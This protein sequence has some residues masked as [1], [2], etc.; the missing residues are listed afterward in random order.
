MSSILEW[1]EGRARD[2]DGL[3]VRRVLPHRGGR[4]IGP[5]IFFDH[6][7]PTELKPGHGMDVRPH[8]HIC[9]STV[10]YL[11]EGEILHR[12]S[13]GSVQT[14]T[15]GAINWMTAG[16]GIVHSERT[17]G[18]LRKT[19]GRMHGI[20]TW[21]AL[22]DAE[23]ERDPGFFHIPASDLPAWEKD[24]LQWNLLVGAAFGRK[25]ALDVYWP[26]SYLHV[27]SQNGGGTTLPAD[28]S[29]RGIYT[30]NGEVRIDGE[31][32]PVGTMA[33]LA[34]GVTPELRL[35]AG[36]SLMLIGGEPVG[37]RLIWWNFVAPT[38]ARLEQ[39]K[40]DWRAGRFA[41]VPDETEFIPMPGDEAAKP[42]PAGFN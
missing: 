21:V 14:I 16:R 1:I 20:Q 6:M 12:D 10:T 18:R 3:A 39:A 7:G 30:V 22:P 34:K 11:F 32:I 27:T 23:L 35:G 19:G 9:L 13:V 31:A 25:V 33:S 8:P 24:G 28:F 5:W 40:Q 41:R 26:M 15:P 2:V 17:P 37:K 42:T 38:E 4:M 36:A 29:E